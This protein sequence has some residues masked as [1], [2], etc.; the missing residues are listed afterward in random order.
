MLEPSPS[1]GT[2]CLS[3]ILGEQ[4]IAQEEPRFWRMPTLLLC[5]LFGDGFDRETVSASIDECDIA[6]ILFLLFL[7]GVY[8]ISKG[9]RHVQTQNNHELFQDRTQKDNHRLL[10]TRQDPVRCLFLESF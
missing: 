5:W 4:R 7:L 6:S 2:E 10:D 9:I 3:R 1:A 8:M